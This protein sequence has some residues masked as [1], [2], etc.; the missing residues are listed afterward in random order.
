MYTKQRH[1]QRHARKAWA[2]TLVDLCL[3]S[4]YNRKTVGRARIYLSHLLIKSKA[5]VATTI[6]FTALNHSFSFSRESLP[7]LASPA[8]HYVDKAILGFRPLTRSS[9]PLILAYPKLLLGLVE[10]VFNTFAKHE[11]TTVRLVA[12]IWSS[13]TEIFLAQTLNHEK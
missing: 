12:D 7:C 5:Q 13:A 6:F 3:N 11:I 9:A 4:G 10:K 1:E 2:G 8:S